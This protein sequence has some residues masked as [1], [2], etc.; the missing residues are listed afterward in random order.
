MGGCVCVR[1]RSSASGCVHAFMR[2]PC[3][4]SEM[5]IRVCVLG[6]SECMS[7]VV[8][9]LECAC[10]RAGVGYLIGVF[11]VTIVGAVIALMYFFKEDV[12]KLP[13]IENPE[14]RVSPTHR[15][16]VV[17]AGPTPGPAAPANPGPDTVVR[18]ATAGPGAVQPVS[19]VF[20]NMSY[21]VPLPGGGSKKL[22]QNITGYALPGTLTALM[23]AS[24][25]RPRGLSRVLCVMGGA[26]FHRCWQ[27]HAVGRDFRAED[28]RNDHW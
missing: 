4:K 21:S 1:E 11:V 27:N 9:I 22:L 19:L 25:E 15:R 28:W 23:G 10:V 3:C 26:W 5:S 13:Y 8:S 17:W 24:G 16:R 6:V 7:P 12:R 18:V 20:R 14:K 2:L